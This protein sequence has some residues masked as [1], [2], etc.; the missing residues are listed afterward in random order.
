MFQTSEF[1]VEKDSK[2]VANSWI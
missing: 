1:T 2:I